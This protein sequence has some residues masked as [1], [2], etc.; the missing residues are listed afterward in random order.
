MTVKRYKIGFRVDQDD[1]LN[2]L[3][4]GGE[5]VNLNEVLA[6]I[7]TVIDQLPNNHAMRNGAVLAYNAISASQLQRQGNDNG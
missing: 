5:L 7:Q 1:K 2:L 6:A 4:D 3:W